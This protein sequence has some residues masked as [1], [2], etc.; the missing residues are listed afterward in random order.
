MSRHNYTQY[1]RN[2]E[3]REVVDPEL[4]VA[5]TTAM[6]EVEP[7]PEVDPV[8]ETVE[9]VT[10]PEPTPAPVTGTIANCTKLN[11]RVKPA[12]DADV[13]CVLNAG[14]KL[15]ID[16]DRSTSDWFKV[17]TAGVDGYCMR[18]FVNANL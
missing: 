15:E 6:A 5:I 9:T 7:T 3:E 4:E 12:S 1:S 11:I 13:V 18:R 16:V 14:T 2:K 17:S 10:Q 8:Q